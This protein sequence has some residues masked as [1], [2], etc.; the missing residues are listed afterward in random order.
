MTSAGAPYGPAAPPCPDDVAGRPC[1]DFAVCAYCGGNVDRPPVPAA[2]EALQRLVEAYFDDDDST[3]RKIKDRDD[4]IDAAM[5][6]AR[7]LLAGLSRTGTEAEEETVTEWAVWL[8]RSS[9]PL[10]TAERSFV[11]AWLMNGSD[12]VRVE[13]RQ[14]ITTCSRWV[15]VPAEETEDSDA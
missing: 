10:I 3:D 1:S 5:Y 4:E 12:V 9:K 11:D 14:V 8:E 7:D 2:V 13:Q 15:P 6:E